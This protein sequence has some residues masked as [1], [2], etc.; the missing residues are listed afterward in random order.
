MKP[1]Q[2]KI[3]LVTGASRGIGRACAL[4]LAEA[5]ADVAVNCRSN[6][7]AAQEVCLLISKMGQRAQA[8]QADVSREEEAHNMVEAIRQDLGPVSILVNNAGITR[9]KTFIK[10][11]KSMWDEVLGVNLNGPFNVTHELVGQMIEVGWG[12]IVN[13][14]S[15]VGQT[16]NFGQANYAVTKGGLIAFTMT[17]A[18][19]VARKGITV[20]AVAPG[21][22]E[23]DMT[24]DVPPATLEQ[25]KAMTPIG[26]LGKAEE[27]AAAVAF[28]A[29]PQASY[30][31]GQVLPVNG[32]MYM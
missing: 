23:T 20:N 11:T 14:T 19:E 18:R 4:A 25:V 24:K 17:L 27:V 31:T 28:L 8:Y 7:A 13:I 1:L 15:I 12:R 29:S 9:D 5:G 2:G 26:R 6:L 30:I 22:I 16:G 3:A 32:G 10:M 21:F